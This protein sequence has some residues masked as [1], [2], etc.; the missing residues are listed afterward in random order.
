MNVYVAWLLLFVGPTTVVVYGDFA[1]QADCERVVASLRI[2]PLLRPPV[3]VEV[4]K[5]KP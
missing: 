3:C 1:T 2:N 5:V 4:K